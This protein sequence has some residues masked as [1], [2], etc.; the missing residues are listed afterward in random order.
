[1]MSSDSRVDGSPP[2]H[3]AP[4]EDIPPI[5][6]AYA[7]EEPSG[8]AIVEDDFS[9]PDESATEAAAVNG[10]GPEAS[11]AAAPGVG[12]DVSDT[13]TGAMP[14]EAP[15]RRPSEEP[16]GEIDWDREQSAH[17]IVVELKRIEARVREILEGR[18]NKR[19]RKLGGTRRWQDLE[20]D[21]IAWHDTTRFDAPTLARLREL[22]TKRHYLFRRLRFLAGTHGTWNS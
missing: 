8:S 12:D 21:L 1:M 5:E 17:R 16:E 18:D 2:E 9:E 4:K 10:S 15:E 3:G 11:P 19:K 20:E 14:F 7:A 22:I 6:D 13:D